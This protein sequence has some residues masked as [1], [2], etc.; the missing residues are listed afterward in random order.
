[1]HTHNLYFSEKLICNST[2][3]GATTGRPNC[4]K[5]VFCGRP[6]VA[7]MFKICFYLTRTKVFA[8]IR[9]GNKG[10]PFSMYSCVAPGK[11]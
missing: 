3:V 9:Q 5:S 4:D 1:M 11:K 6:P 7:P 10:H 2:I 8:K